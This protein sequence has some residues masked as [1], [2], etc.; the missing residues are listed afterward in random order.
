M[1]K[2][3]ITDYYLIVTSFVFFK[4]QTD[5]DFISG[6]KI[7]LT[8]YLTLQK[9]TTYVKTSSVC[10]QINLPHKC[11]NLKYTFF[12]LNTILKLNMFLLESKT[13]LT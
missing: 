10:Q 12:L 9:S 7:V 8:I 4:K 5:S 11:F 1:T 6:E 2:M 13:I 3:F